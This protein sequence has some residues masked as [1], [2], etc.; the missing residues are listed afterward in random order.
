MEFLDQIQP[1]WKHLN[2][3]HAEVS[4]YFSSEFQQKQFVDRKAK[5]MQKYI[6][7]QLRVDLAQSQGHSIGYLVTAVNA[8]KVGEIES[9][10][11]ETAFR[12]RGIAAE[13]MRRGL[14]WL[15]DQGIHSKVLAVAVG[16]ERAYAFYKRFGF[17]PRVVML[18]QKDAS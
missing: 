1:L 18:H 11:V 17:Y 9:I 5:L 4:P 6:N 2:Q 3:H 15:D 7:G 12:G 13:L 10:F 14:A 8:E 16:N